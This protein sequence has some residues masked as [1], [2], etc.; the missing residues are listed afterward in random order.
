MKNHFELS[1]N[2]QR[3]IQQALN[4]DIG[5]GD[6]TTNSIVPQQAVMRG[7]IIA[8]QAG[9]ISGLTIAQTVYHLLD[10]DVKFEALVDEGASVDDKQKLANVY[11]SARILLTAERTAL[12]FVGRMSGISTLTHQFVKAVA[13]TNTKILD[14][15]KT[16]PGLR[17]FDKLAVRLGGGMN[18]R[19]GLYDMI[20]IKDNHIDFAGSL[21]EAV[22]R[23]RAAKSGLEIEVETR[24]LDDVAVAL[25]LGVERILLDNMSCDMMKQA[26]VMTAGRAKLEASGNITLENVRDV[27]LTGV[28]YISTGALTHSVK[29]FDVSFDYLK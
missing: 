27:A 2:M 24:T 22:N 3:I 9:I 6:I 23:A 28:D 4:E 12:N 21:K 17:E 7:E 11:G 5:S 16:V 18:H 10:A 15:R 13:G 1:E 8:K 25:E 20:L 26:V 19:V 29:V 14:T